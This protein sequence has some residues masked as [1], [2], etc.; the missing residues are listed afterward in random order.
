MDIEVKEYDG[1]GLLSKETADWLDPTHE[2]H[3]FQIR[4]P[5]LLSGDDGIRLLEMDSRECLERGIA[6]PSFPK[7]A[8]TSLVVVNRYGV[9]LHLLAPGDLHQFERTFGRQL[10]HSPEHRGYLGVGA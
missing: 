1:E 5:Y 9:G 8:C 7:K 4:L 2:H 10:H 6:H 3:S